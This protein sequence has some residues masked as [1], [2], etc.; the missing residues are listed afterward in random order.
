MTIILVFSFFP[1]KC[2]IDQ[3]NYGFVRLIVTNHALSTAHATP[4]QKSMVLHLNY[5]LTKAKQSI[6]VVHKPHPYPY[7]S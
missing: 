1:I 6:H 4:M 7:K 5:Q 3:L 2:I